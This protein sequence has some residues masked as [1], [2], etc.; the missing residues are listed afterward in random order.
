M[1]NRLVEL[2]NVA[3]LAGASVLEPE[4]NGAD[5]TS[6]RLLIKAFDDP[7]VA[8]VTTSL[9]HAGPACLRR[10]RSAACG[11]CERRQSRPRAGRRLPGRG[12]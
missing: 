2:L 5:I 3:P 7:F 9:R 4:A 10:F 8:C 6:K 1:T 11:G 12:R